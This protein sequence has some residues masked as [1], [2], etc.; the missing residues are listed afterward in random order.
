MKD[1]LVF[2]YY[3][4]VIAIGNRNQVLTRK[5]P[6]CCDVAPLTKET[7]KFLLIDR[8][9]FLYWKTNMVDMTPCENQGFVFA[10]NFDGIFKEGLNF[11][12]F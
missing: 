4:P 7:R 3:P 2:N 11:V 12:V 10:N 5:Q 8:I 1:L 6:K 9:Q